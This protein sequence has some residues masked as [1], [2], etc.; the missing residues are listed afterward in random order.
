MKVANVVGARPQF[1]KAAAVCAAANEH[2]DIRN[3]LVHTGQHY[4]ADMSDIFF[5]QLGIQQPDVELGIGSGP[6]GEQ[7]AQMMTALEGTLR[8][9][10]PDVVLVYGDTNTTLAA[11]YAGWRLGIPVGHVESG[12]RSYN[13][14]M[15]EEINRIVTDRVSTILFSPSQTGVDNLAREGIVDG[16]HLVGDVMGDL[17]FRSVTRARMGILGELGVRTGSFFLMTLHRP[18][19]TDD[20]G[21]LERILRAVAQL[22]YPVIFPVHPRTRAAMEGFGLAAQGN[23][24]PIAPVGYLE[25]LA[26]QMHARAILTDSGGMQKEAYFLGV[27]CVTLREETEWPETV[28][29]GWNLL[30]GPDPEKLLAAIDREIPEAHPDLYGDGHTAQAIVEI[31]AKEISSKVPA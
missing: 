12:L 22:P 13:R 30:V 3:L 10:S 8:D 23:L 17:L 19:N 2:G 14:R 26:L 5:S 24:K 9:L 11:A 27:P 16:V 28:T 25:I 18:S 20:P 1:I 4:D 21:N 31:L 6:H 29:A 7:T 15:P